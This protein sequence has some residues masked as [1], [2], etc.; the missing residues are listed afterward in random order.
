MK[1]DPPDSPTRHAAFE[2]LLER[3]HCDFPMSADESGE[4]VVFTY[5][6]QRLVRF[7]LWQHVS[8]PD[9]CADETF[10]R[11]AT[12][13]ADGEQIQD[14]RAYLFG[15]A[16]MV[17]REWATRE[18]RRQRALHLFAVADSTRQLSGDQTP[19]TAALDCLRCCL[20]ELSPQ[21]QDLIR[22]YYTGDQQDRIRNRAQLA[23][24][25]GLEMNALRN[26]A[27]RLRQRLEKCIQTCMEK[28]GPA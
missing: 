4:D 28:R 7:F 22:S 2:Q 26:K 12:K 10:A 11:V 1:P 8:D 17:A 5:Y 24:Q 3:L 19:S 6:R 25:L 27:M 23:E 21:Q 13:L 9:L 16:R 18:L 20:R 15:T 14:M